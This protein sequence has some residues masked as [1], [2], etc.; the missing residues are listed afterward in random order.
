MTLRV[1]IGVGGRFHADHMAAA[2]LKAGHNVRL[3]TSYPRSRFPTLPNGVVHSIP[4]PEIVSRVLNAL[5]LSNAGDL[6]K[7]ERFGQ[8]VAKKIVA[9][10]QPADLFIGWSSF[11]LETLRLNH[12]A[13][14]FLI[15]DSAHILYQTEILE[16]EYQELK[17]NFP[18]RKRCIDRELAEYDMADGILVLSQFAK[19]TFIERGFDTS[20][21]HVL[22]LGVDTA[23]FKRTIP[24]KR[25]APFK[26]VYFGAINAR[27]G[28]HYLLEAVSHFP[29]ESVETYVVG[30][31]DESYRR[32]LRKYSNY[33]LV[34]PMPHRKLVSFLEDKDIFVL[35]TLEDGFSM[36]LIQAMAIGLVPI[37]TDHCGA[38]E[39]V[40]TGEN[41]FVVP[42]RD[43]AAIRA[44][45]S[46]LICNPSRLEAMAC[47]ASE[48]AALQTWSAYEERINGW[49]LTQFHRGAA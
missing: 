31:I 46:E 6:F 14:K 18:N 15:R 4:F 25:T 32:V 43:H 44:K 10:G 37:V 28:I 22:P 39:F 45:I 33:K 40:H 49:A 1:D 21:I 23:L 2:F 7:I 27:K 36:A 26:I 41:G 13:K 47:R 29:K 16:Q 38:A 8:A 35:P 48:T 17:L 20:K 12:A 9:S 24:E 5:W 3:F 34:P 42:V 11:S 19:Q 30:G